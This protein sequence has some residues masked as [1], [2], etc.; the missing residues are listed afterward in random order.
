MHGNYAT[1][2][3]EATVRIQRRIPIFF[4]FFFFVMLKSITRPETVFKI[5]RL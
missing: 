4:F 2:V 3:H 1:S 5:Q